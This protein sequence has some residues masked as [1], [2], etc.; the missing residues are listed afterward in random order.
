[1]KLGLVVLGHGPYTSWRPHSKLCRLW[2][3]H[4]VLELHTNSEQ[5]EI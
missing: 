5:E 1:V 3:L 4:H 2:M